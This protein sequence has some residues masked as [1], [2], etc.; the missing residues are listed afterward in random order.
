MTEVLIDVAPP[1]AS[2]PEIYSD[3]PTLE[4]M[5]AHD[6]NLVRGFTFN[7]TLFRNLGVVDYAAHSQKVV[8]ACG[9]LPLSLEVFADDESGMIK[10]AVQLS[11]FGENVYVKIPITYTSGKSTI[12]V[13]RELADRG[14][15]VNVTAVFSRE[16]TE[17]VLPALRDSESII[18]VFSGRLFDIGRDA[19][20]DTLRISELVHAES[21]CKTLWAS[22]RMS[23]DVKSAEDAGCDIITMKPSLIEKLALFGKTPEEY[24]LDTVKMFYRDAVASGYTL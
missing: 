8:E 2:V 3:G 10:Q 20:E 7:P 24:S 16:Q 9:G 18:S 12:A 21:N 1:L 14:I 13:L 11:A 6:H 19:V 5:A 4:E 15:K 17:R 22:P 23:Y